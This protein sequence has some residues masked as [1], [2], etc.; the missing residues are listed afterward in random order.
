MMRSSNE[1]A[2]KTITQAGVIHRGGEGALER[3]LRRGL[4]GF[5]RVQVSSGCHMWVLRLSEPG[6]T[7]VRLQEQGRPWRGQVRKSV[8]L[9]VVRYSPIAFFEFYRDTF[10]D[11]FEKT[12]DQW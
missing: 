2:T 12:I 3:L 11:F 9:W 1:N 4:W 7:C 6:A 8:Y 5:Q 10:F